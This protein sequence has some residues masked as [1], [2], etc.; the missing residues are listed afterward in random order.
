MKK[1]HRWHLLKDT[2]L[3]LVLDDSNW[4]C[5]ISGLLSIVEERR[6]QGT[7]RASG[8]GWAERA[9][10]TPPKNDVSFFSFNQNTDTEAWVF[11][12]Y[13]MFGRWIVALTM[14]DLGEHWNRGTSSQLFSCLNFKGRTEGIM[15]PF[16]TNSLPVK[17]AI[18]CWFTHKKRVIFHTKMLVYRRVIIELTVLPRRRGPQSGSNMGIWS[19]IQ[20]NA[21]IFLVFFFLEIGLPYSTGWSYSLCF[22]DSHNWV[23][24]PLSDLALPV[25]SEHRA[26]DFPWNLLQKY[27]H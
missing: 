25:D 13:Q 21:G 17:M 23:N 8:D 22:L 3:F 16:S 12:Q 2:H 14:V 27:P 6:R 9:N 11:G 26:F 18:F 15:K 10:R 20:L 24:P 4:P 1:I 7:C 5:R 19:P